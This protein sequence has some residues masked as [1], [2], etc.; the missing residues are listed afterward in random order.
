MQRH[1]MGVLMC[2]PVC[3]VAWQCNLKPTHTNKYFKTIA[4]R[5][6]MQNSTFTDYAMCEQQRDMQMVREQC[7]YV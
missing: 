3:G 5:L 1:A 4:E 2:C 7:Y 6:Y